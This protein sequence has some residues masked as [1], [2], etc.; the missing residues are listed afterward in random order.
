M[1]PIH[2]HRFQPQS[3]FPDELIAKAEAEL[4][5]SAAI[6]QA[7]GIQVYRPPDEINWLAVNGYTGAMPRDG[8]MSIGNTLIEA[9]FAWPCRSSEIEIGFSSI[10]DTVSQDPRV[11]V[12]RR[13]ESSFANTLLNDGKSY[14]TDGTTSPWAINNSRPAFDAADFMRF[15]HTVLGQYSHVTNPAG[16]EYVQQHLP[17]GYEIEMLDVNDPHAMHIDATIMP[18]RDGLLVYNP[19]KV[20]EA[21]LRRHAVLASWISAH[22]FHPAGAHGSSTVHDQP[23]AVPQRSGPRRDARGGGG[24]RPADGAVVR[25]AR[26]AM[27]PVPVQ[28]RQ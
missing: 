26:H 2:I 13:P 20:T 22:T 9:C 19:T 14:Q 4:D 6:L 24:E 16:V 21:A 1:P 25:V 3:P 27:H 11:Q 5:Y 17:A 12:V 8:L 18:L 23:L 15:G 10:L 28:A 7:E